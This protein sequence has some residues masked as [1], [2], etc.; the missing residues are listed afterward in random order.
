M[1]NVAVVG[2][3]GAVG[4][5]LLS[6]LEARNFPVG[7]L[8]PLASSRSAGSTVSFRGERLMVQEA[9][10][11]AFAG[12]D[13]V[14]FAATGLLSRELAPAA[15]RA[16]AVVIDKS[17]TWRMDPEV[18]LVVPEVNPEDLRRH[19]GIIAS[20]NC[21]TIG[22]VM[23]LKPLHDLA[24]ITRVIVTT[25][26]AVSGTGKE[27]IEE[28]EQQ[29]RAWTEGHRGELPHTV[30]KRQIAFN[31]LPYAETF[32]ENLYTTEEMKL[33]AETRKIM[34]LPDLPVTMTCTRVPVFVGHSESVL[35]EF[36]RKVTPAEAR[37]AL[38]RF[39]GVRVVDDPL[40]FVF[41]TAIDAAGTDDTL[42]GR[43]REDLTNE[44]GLWLW[45]VSDNL[46]KGAATN[47]VQIA[48]KLLEM[49]L[50]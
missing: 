2:A 16:G 41:P 39:P 25:M 44:K 22:L 36:E 9:T 13:L 12:M 23:A 42:V 49:Q 48:E 34:G 29:V 30:Y 14:F 33:S 32:T 26:Q 45:I 18:P 6:L 46:R 3:T 37:E 47:A 50:I 19:K 1:K 38:S 17:S 10:P 43:I 7:R 5:E 40:Q 31:V 21:T 8:L 15:A 35:V 27:A 24:R 11:E 4:Q 28:L 20:P